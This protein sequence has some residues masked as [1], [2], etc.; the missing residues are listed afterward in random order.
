M[1]RWHAG[2]GS[3]WGRGRGAG[4]TLLPAQDTAVSRLSPGGQWAWA[5]HHCPG[6]SQKWPGAHRSRRPV[7][8]NPSSAC[9]TPSL[10]PNSLS[11][12]QRG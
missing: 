9:F 8:C 4:D 11:P 2:A 7:A 3:V 1:A 5:P 6:H 12:V 10:P